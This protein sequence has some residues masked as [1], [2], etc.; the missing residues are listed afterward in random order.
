MLPGREVCKAPPFKHSPRSTTLEKQMPIRS[1]LSRIQLTASCPALDTPC[2]PADFSV[3]VPRIATCWGPPGA[4]WSPHFSL[5]TPEEEKSKVNSTKQEGLWTDKSFLWLWCRTSTSQ[6]LMGWNTRTGYVHKS[7]L[8][9]GYYYKGQRDK[10]EQRAGQI[11]LYRGSVG[12]RTFQ[13]RM[14]TYFKSAGGWGGGSILRT[15]EELN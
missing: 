9:L 15:R 10:I 13:T 6:A 2:S 14:G 11:L 7:E 5:P 8:S 12:S 4:S 1:R 3:S